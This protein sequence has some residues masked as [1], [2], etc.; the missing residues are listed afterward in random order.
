MVNLPS[1]ARRYT[2]RVTRA[3]EVTHSELITARKQIT[4][5][6]KLL[7]SR[8]QRTKGK[9]IALKGKFVFS[10]KEVLEIARTAEAETRARTTKKQSRKR[11]IGLVD[12]EE[13]DQILENDSSSSESDCII[14]SSRR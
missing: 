5:Q 8:K 9:R 13:E 7:T 3:Y 14:I 4:E 12:E 1:P 2:E 10:T 11:T 6:Q